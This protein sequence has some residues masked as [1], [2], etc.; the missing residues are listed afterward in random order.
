MGIGREIAEVSKS[1]GR[2]SQRR[3]GRLPAPAVARA[4]QVLASGRSSTPSP[5]LASPPC[6]G[7]ICG[8][9]HAEAPRRDEDDPAGSPM[10]SASTSMRGPAPMGTRQ[11]SII[12]LERDDEPRQQGRQCLGATQRRDVQPT[13]AV[14]MTT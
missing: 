9:T 12:D 10:M 2:A 14:G 8:T 3:D 4:A 7:C 5:R 11:L 6:S 1:N 13:D